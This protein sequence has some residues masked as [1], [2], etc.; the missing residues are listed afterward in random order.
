MHLNLNWPVLVAMFSKQD[1]QPSM[2]IVV[3]TME[4]AVARWLKQSPKRALVLLS[5][6]CASFDMFSDFNERGEVFKRFVLEE[7]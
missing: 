3:E 5:P 4:H 2:C 1:K 6:G 7:T